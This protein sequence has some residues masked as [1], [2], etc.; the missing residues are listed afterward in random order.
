MLLSSDHLLVEGDLVLLQALY[1]SELR[2]VVHMALHG[3]AVVSGLLSFSIVLVGH[4]SC[5]TRYSLQVTEN[6]TMRKEALLRCLS[7]YFA[8]PN[9]LEPLGT[10]DSDM[11]ICT[12]T[13]PELHEHQSHRITIPKSTNTAPRASLRQV[14]HSKYRTCTLKPRR[15]WTGTVVV[16]HMEDRDSGFW[17]DGGTMEM[18]PQYRLQENDL[19]S[20]LDGT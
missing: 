14:H 11:E 3:T 18:M 9:P 1:A 8:F 19:E 2:L 16:L 17:R 4:Y 6:Y 15:W 12:L 20:T 13:R 5:P 7:P 10:Q